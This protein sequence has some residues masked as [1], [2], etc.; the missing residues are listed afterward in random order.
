MTVAKP[1]LVVFCPGLKPYLSL[2]I[3]SNY[4]LTLSITADD[5]AG[6][7]LAPVII[8]VPFFNAS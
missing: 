7:L 3:F 6:T 1:P 5:N 2:S 4:P 8:V